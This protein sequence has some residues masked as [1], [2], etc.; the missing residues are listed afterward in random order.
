M[1]QVQIMAKYKLMATFLTLLVAP[2]FAKENQ[3]ELDFNRDRFVS[4][5]HATQDVTGVDDL[6]MF[7]DTV[8]SEQDI[9]GSIHIFGRKVFSK[10]AV[11]QDAYLSGYKV[12]QTGTV[13]GDLTVSGIDLKLGDVGGDLRAAGDRVELTGEVL[14]YALIAGDEVEFSG[15]VRGDVSLKT[16]AITFAKGAHI[17]GN[18]TIFETHAGA[19][20][21]PEDVIPEER[22]ERRDVAEW[23]AVTGEVEFWDWRKALGQFLIAVL[24]I[25]AIAA[26]FAA[27]VPQKLADL[28]RNILDHPAWSLLI[29]FLTMS[30]IIGSTIVLMITGYGM[31]LIPINLAILFLAVLTGF[32]VGAY[33]IGV[34]IML[35][36]K[37]TEPSSFGTRALAAAIGAL[38]AVVLFMLPYFGWLLFLSILFMGLGSII[39]WLFRP[40]FFAKTN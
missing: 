24:F 22:I 32:V 29:G 31:K 23:D 34:G 27:I 14:G 11:G 33:A 17:E 9:S 40:R 20:Q 16:E 38:A 36:A 37:Q 15:T 21:I 5:T 8:H 18:L 4:G 19:A 28:R 25:T 7:G 2:L 26:W 13:N 35:Q 3:S 39:Q 6:F 30:I 1:K 12:S 10:G